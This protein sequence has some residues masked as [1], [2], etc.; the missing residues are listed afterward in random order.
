[1]TLRIVVHAQTLADRRRGASVTIIA[2]MIA[3]S[4]RTGRRIFVTFAVLSVALLATAAAWAQG[5]SHA[6]IAPGDPVPPELLVEQGGAAGRAL[7]A[8]VQKRPV[9]MVYWRP[10]HATSEQTLVSTSERLSEEAPGVTLLPVAVLAAGQSPDVIGERLTALG[11][12]GHAE[13]QDGGQLAMMIGVRQAPSFVLIDAGGVLRLIGGADLGQHTP[14]G[15]SILDAVMKAN[16]GKPVP[17]LGALP[18]DPVYQLLGKP[19]PDVAGTA[20]DGKTWTKLRG[21]AGEGKR[22]LIFYWSPNCGHCKRAL[23]ELK[24]WYQTTKPKDLEVVDIGRADSP[25]LEQKVPPLIESYPWT[26]VLDVDR[27]IGRAL[28]A[29]WTPTSYL[30]S[31]EGRIVDI[32]LG[33]NID[34]HEWL[35]EGS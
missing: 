32:R 21:M 9:L 24:E 35:S 28:L 34:W 26:H 15:L 2:R 1:M 23:P 27:S 33:G 5:G 3:T 25:S 13:L 17:T 29:R 6:L 22:L 16:A 7:A 12:Q 14:D 20:L 10:D 30:V 8:H 11:L 31:A 4:R 18:S 19:L